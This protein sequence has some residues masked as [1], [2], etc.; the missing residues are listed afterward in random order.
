VTLPRGS[1]GRQYRE[2]RRRVASGRGTRGQPRIERRPGQWSLERHRGLRVLFRAFLGWLAGF[3]AHVV[4]SLIAIVGAS[5]LRLLPPVA[6]GLA[7]DHLLGQR[8]TP[9]ALARW[10]PAGLG[11]T[12]AVLAVAY[13]AVALLTIGATTAGR[14]LNAL[15]LRRLQ[16]RLRQRLFEHAAALPLHRIQSY[17]AGGLASLLREDVGS[18]AGLLTTLVFDPARATIQLATALGALALLDWRL[19][20]VGLV[21]AP[22]FALAHRAWV[23]RIRPI[24][25]DVRR[26][27]QR[28]DSHTTQ[29]FAGIRTVRS[30]GMARAE[31][32]R[33]TRSHHLMLRQELLAWWGSTVVDVA[34]GIVAPL[35]AA[36][37]LAYG[38]HRILTDST[39][40][41]RGGLAADQAFTAG[42]LVAAVAYLAMLLEPLAALARSITAAQ[43]GLAALDRVLDVLEDPIPERASGSRRLAPTEVAG[44]VALRHV[45]FRYPESRTPALD[46][47]TLEIPAGA[48]VALVGPSGAGKSTLCNLVARFYEPSAGCVEVDGMDVRTIDPA[49]YRR[50]VAVVEQDVFLFDGT[51]AENV[52]YGA[53]GASAEAIRRAAEAAQAAEFIERLDGGYDT[54]IG[55]R[56]VRLSG[57]QR[58]RLAIAR[59]LLVDPRIL[60]LD[61]ATS[62]LDVEQERLVH[63]GLAALLRG[64]TVI[65]IAHRLSTVLRAHRI[66]VLER[67]RLAGWGSHAELIERSPLYRRLVDAQL[68]DV[69][70]T[71]DA[72]R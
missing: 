65:V 60:I 25:R 50:I 15:V 49:S 2:Y 31:A 43:S 3:R 23:A 18:T 36:G 42:T 40:V 57:G 30:F 66:A 58:K 55:E 35:A 11:A 71:R 70:A 12:V 62:E 39:L 26:L 21:L 16:S 54:W 27:R 68:Q 59:A 56:G 44:R 47:V 7:V 20:A 33:V 63:Q 29:I 34:W 10:L 48:V 45:T 14:Y 51:V 46:D 22:P 5:A 17:T 24:W 28:I 1:S 61:E 52:A 32:S 67:G 38:A 8:A 13:T 69:S 64:R 72:G 53:P 6:L 9:P 19:L 41:A 37:L 4:L